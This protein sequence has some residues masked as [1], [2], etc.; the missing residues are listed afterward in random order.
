MTRKRRR[1]THCMTCH[2]ATNTRLLAMS[3][4]LKLYLSTL[5]TFSTA[6]TKKRGTCRSM[7]RT[8]S[9]AAASRTTLTWSCSSASS[10]STR[11]SGRLSVSFLITGTD[12]SGTRKSLTGSSSMVLQTTAM[13]G[14]TSTLVHQPNPWSQIGI[15]TCSSLFAE[16]SQRRVT[17][18]FSRSRCHPMMSVP[19]SLARSGPRCT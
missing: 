6:K 12:H 1:Q 7:T 10:G 15:S 4:T 19:T 18:H 13:G 3:T 17:S 8:L 9:R 11:M 14:T 2:H 5:Q 16:T